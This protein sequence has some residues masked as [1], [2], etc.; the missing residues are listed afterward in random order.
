MIRKIT[1]AGLVTLFSFQGFAAT[2]QVKADAPDTQRNW[3]PFLDSYNY[4][5]PND[6]LSGVLAENALGVTFKGKNNDEFVLQGVMENNYA[7]GKTEP[8][9]FQLRY[10]RDWTLSNDW[11]LSTLSRVYLPL[12]EYRQTVGQYEFRQYFR[13]NRKLNKTF[14]FRWETH[15]RGYAYSEDE[16]GQRFLLIR[17]LARIS[18]SVTD[19]FFLQSYVGY[20]QDFTHN[21]TKFELQK[22]ETEWKETARQGNNAIFLLVAPIVASE[23]VTIVPAAEQFH[24]VGNGQFKL[25]NPE[26]TVYSF[27]VTVEI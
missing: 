19:K 8:L 23:N 5:N 2:Q 6:G 10:N 11:N 22:P 25:L 26:E 3:K 4:S 14:S 27:Y 20:Q 17:H 16:L 12:S 24:K 13:F 18:M 9:H 15:A 21:G 7:T 1:V